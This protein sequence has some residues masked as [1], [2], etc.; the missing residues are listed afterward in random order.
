MDYYGM[1]IH[2]RYSVFTCLDERG[3]VVRRGR[4]ANTPEELVKAVAP[5]GGEA[6][7]V[8]WW[9]PPATGAMST[10]LWSLG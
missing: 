4:V 2:K 5:S 7:V 10:M 9:R 3:R 1:D 6:K 8:G